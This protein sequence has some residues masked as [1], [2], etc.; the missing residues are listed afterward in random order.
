MKRVAYERNSGTAQKG[1]AARPTLWHLAAML[2][3]V[4]AMTCGAYLFN[5]TPEKLCT[6]GAANE[7]LTHIKVFAICVIFL[8]MS[9]FLC[10]LLDWHEKQAS[11]KR[12]QCEEREGV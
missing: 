7:N 6:I 5:L 1:T 12:E 4:L 11:R 9:M 10:D 3:A 2:A 8:G